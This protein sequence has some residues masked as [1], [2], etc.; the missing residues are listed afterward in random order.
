MN[1][2][3][4]ILK[5][6]PT[7]LFNVTGRINWLEDTRS[8]LCGP[9]KIKKSV[10][11]GLIAD[12]TGS[13]KI[14]IW[15]S[16]IADVVEDTPLFITSVKCEDYFGVRLSTIS[17]SSLSKFE[18]E[19]HVDWGKFDLVPQQT[20]LCCPNIESVKVNSFLKCVNI[21]C[22]RK[23]SPFPGETKVTCLNVTCKRKML[24]KRC[25]KSFN[26]DL[27]VSDK[28]ND[29]IQHSITLFTQVLH[30]IIEVG[31]KINEIIEDELLEIENF[32]FTINKKKVPSGQFMVKRRLKNVISTYITFIQRCFNVV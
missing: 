30:N 17:N 11:L 31:D 4:D 5:N 22:K 6:Q 18:N 13:I 12:E 27:L 25:K 23:V 29:N 8:V 20:T 26:V 9:N 7:A 16:L 14:S 15:G 10:H 2:I 19:I 24:V 32:D 28:D 21:E 1:K 3:E